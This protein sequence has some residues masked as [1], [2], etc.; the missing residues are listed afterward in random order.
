MSWWWDESPNTLKI[1]K[2]FKI[3]SYIIT[4]TATATVIIFTDWNSITKSDRHIFSNF[5]PKAK[6]YLKQLFKISD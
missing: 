6:S 3:F 5:S 2:R 4:A 1:H